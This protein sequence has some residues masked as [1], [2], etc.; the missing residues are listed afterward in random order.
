MMI[1]K[2]SS[3]WN[4]IQHSLFPKLESAL[5]HRLTEEHKKVGQTLEIL[6]V[7]ETIK[8]PHS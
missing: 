5:D 4:R 3:Y 8:Q 6:R 1:P 7:E 2:L